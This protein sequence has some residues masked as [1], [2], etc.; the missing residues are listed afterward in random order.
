MKESKQGR[1]AKVFKIAEKIRGP[2]K[3]FS[4]PQAIKDPFSGELVVSSQEI[5]KVCLDHCVKTLQ[6]NPVEK[7]FLGFILFQNF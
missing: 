4:E 6:D 1:S 2:K 7:G 3:G 5:K